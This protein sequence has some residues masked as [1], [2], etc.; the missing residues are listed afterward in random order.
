M[1]C[2]KNIYIYIIGYLMCTPC[3]YLL[4]YC[5]FLFVLGYL[6]ENKDV[7]KS[8]HHVSPKANC[9]QIFEDRKRR[10]DVVGY[11]FNK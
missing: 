2:V 5:L 11:N 8:T 6:V 10:L 1:D 7:I 3:I 9:R 4:I